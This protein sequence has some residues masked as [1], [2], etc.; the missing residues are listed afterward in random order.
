MYKE[1]LPHS[2]S[3]LVLGI[4]SIVTACC[5]WGVIGLIIGI[6]GLIESNKAIAIY[7]ESPES[8]D[9]I[10]NAE[11]GRTTSIIGIVIGAISLLWMIYMYT[12][13]SYEM[14]F[15]QYEELLDEGS[16]Y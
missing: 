10:N 14:I 13:G 15:E 16:T 3:A 7:S 8:F 11:T 6:I 4:S 12:S 5:C 9:G 1:R 2:Q